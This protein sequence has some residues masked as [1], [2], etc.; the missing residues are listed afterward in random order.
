MDHFDVIVVGGGPAGSAAAIRSAQSGA[1]VVLIE[2]SVFPRHRP[3]ETLHPGIEP[4]LQQLGVWDVITEANFIR[5]HAIRI[6]CGGQDMIRPFG[7]DA[8]GQWYGLQAWREE[9]DAL[10]LNRAREL[11]VTIIQPCTV[12]RTIFHDDRVNGVITS[13][14]HISADFTIDAAG[15]RHWLANEL[16]LPLRLESSRL[17]ARYGYAE[18]DLPDNW[19]H[20][21]LSVDEN[22]WTWIARVRSRIF[23]WTRLDSRFSD[24]EFAENVVPSQLR[25]LRQTGHAT[26]AVVTWRCVSA[27]AGRGYFLTGAAAAVLDPA[28]SHGVLKAIMSGIYAGHLIE[29]IRNK[30]RNCDSAAQ[31]YSKW[32]ARWFQHDVASL[33]KMYNEFGLLSLATP[34]Y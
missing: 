11:G 20:P 24:S 5:H 15:G 9:F 1:R 28:S 33:R 7:S 8:N 3:G 23:Q 21:L 2:R 29:Q 34:H 13:T 27:S 31:E 30:K 16:K 6:R 10:L 4:L 18:G 22:G 17:I 26:G 25:G 12:E 14:G 19:D 32:I